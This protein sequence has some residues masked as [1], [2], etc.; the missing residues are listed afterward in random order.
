MHEPQRNCGFFGSS[1]TLA[2]CGSTT[3]GHDGDGGLALASLDLHKQEAVVP[4][5]LLLLTPPYARLVDSQ[6]NILTHVIMDD[7]APGKQMHAFLYDDEHICPKVI[8]EKGPALTEFTS[9]LQVH[10][11]VDSVPIGLR[12]RHY[13]K[14]GSHVSHV[15]FG[16]GAP[17]VNACGVSLCEKANYNGGNGCC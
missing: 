2:D 13:V 16:S 5:K 17:L 3:F 14:E 11:Y 4:N 9:T 6:L 10:L 7:T 1:R 12:A 8:H 15:L